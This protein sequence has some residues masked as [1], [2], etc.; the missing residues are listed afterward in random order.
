VLIKRRG[1]IA[2]GIGESSLF[3]FRLLRMFARRNIAKIG[4][5]RCT[6]GSANKLV[7]TASSQRHDPSLVAVAK[8][9]GL[10]RTGRLNERG[11]SF[12]DKGQ[13]VRMTRVNQ[14]PPSHSSGE[15]PNIRIVVGLV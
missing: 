10:T 13:V 15:P 6:L 12:R 3:E 4:N 2:Q 14:F 5:N 1:S 11:K 9:G 8:L 7:P